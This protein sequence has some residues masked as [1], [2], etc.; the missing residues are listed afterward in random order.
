MHLNIGIWCSWRRMTSVMCSLPLCCV[1]SAFHT[2]PL[3][4]PSVPPIHV[5]FMICFYDLFL[6]V[7]II[8]SLRDLIG[9]FS[10]KQHS[11]IPALTL[12]QSWHNRL[13][14]MCAHTGLPFQSRVYSTGWYAGPHTRQ[15]PEHSSS[16]VPLMRLDTVW[17]FIDLYTFFSFM[18]LCFKITPPRVY[19][20][21]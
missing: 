5:A 15:K 13:W 20:H 7:Y 12:G 16:V 2:N 17:L 4:S 10:V 11:L 1:H 18:V 6:I 19:A 8:P 9:V 14:V 3:P 21:F